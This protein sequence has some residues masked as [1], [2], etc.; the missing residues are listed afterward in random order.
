MDFVEKAR[1]FTNSGIDEH[2]GLD[3]PSIDQ[4][5]PLG[6]LPRR[7][8]MEDEGQIALLSNAQEAIPVHFERI[9]VELGRRIGVCVVS[10]LAESIQERPTPVAEV[11]L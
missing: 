5:V 6:T 3:V 2:A 10:T 8:P 4:S 1:H 7:E 11:V 9:G